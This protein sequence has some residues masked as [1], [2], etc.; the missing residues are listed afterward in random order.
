MLLD[1]C[2]NSIGWNLQVNSRIKGIFVLPEKFFWL[3]GIT[4][5]YLRIG[6]CII[7]R[8]TVAYATSLD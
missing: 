4:N 7:F 2:Q 5:L 6:S 3:A 8:L 1:D